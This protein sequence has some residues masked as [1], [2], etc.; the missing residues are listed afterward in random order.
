MQLRFLVIPAVAGIMASLAPALAQRPAV[1]PALSPEAAAAAFNDAVIAVCVPAVSQGSIPAAARA[2]LQQTNDAAIRKQAGAADDETVWD[3]MAGKGV[4]TVHEKSG[5]C[6]VS[7]YGPPAMA[8]ITG[9]ATRLVDSDFERLAG[10]ATPNGFTQTLT[11]T[12]SG[13]RMMVVLKGSDPGLPGHQSRFSVVT[14]TVFS[15]P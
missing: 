14:A 11:R 10:S 13:K 2:M 8:T 3:V 1:S 15:A 5:R 7:V 9:A 4:V 12:D 6:T